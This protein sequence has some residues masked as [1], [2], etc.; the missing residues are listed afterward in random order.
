MKIICTGRNYL[1]HIREM[2]NEIPV[3]PQIFLKSESSYLANNSV[4]HI[5]SYATNLQ[6]E[7]EIVLKISKKGKNIPESEAHQYFNEITI[8]IDFTER[9]LQAKMIKDRLSWELAKAFDESA[10]V[11]NFIPV[12]EI[13]N[14][15]DFGFHF[16]RNGQTVQK[17][18][19]NQLVFNFYHLIS[20][21]SVYFTLQPGDL[22]YTGTP[23][24]VNRVYP[25][26]LLEGFIT[27]QKLLQITVK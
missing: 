21:I 6:Y 25:G 17:S 5:P 7:A 23:S 2:N 27:N 22:I 26:D 9:D 3:E 1:D 16:N 14:I 18:N 20:F 8:G 10:A 19:V 4:F 15:L 11:G 13:N 12:S 24:G